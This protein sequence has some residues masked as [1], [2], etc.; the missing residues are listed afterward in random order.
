[1]E[2]KKEETVVAHCKFKKK[3]PYLG[4]TLRD[5]QEIGYGLLQ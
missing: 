5:Q 1:M 2:S 3:L 4:N